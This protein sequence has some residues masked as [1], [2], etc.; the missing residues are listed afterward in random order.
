MRLKKIKLKDRYEQSNLGG[1]ECI[2]PL[3]KGVSEDQDL[4]QYEYDIILQ[5]SRELYEDT[6]PGGAILQRRRE[7]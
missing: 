7:E 3:R 5:K 4:L 1:F 6:L 2:Y